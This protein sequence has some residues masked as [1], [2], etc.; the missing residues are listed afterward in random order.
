[1][2]LEELQ[3]KGK[4]TVGNLTIGGLGTYALLI[5]FAG[6]KVAQMHESQM[7][8]ASQ[9][10]VITQ[11]LTTQEQTINQLKANSDLNL[12]LQERMERLE[13]QVMHKSKN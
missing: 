10:A 9:I 5:F 6:E 12:K 3:E 7:Q 13:E 8:T 1:M 4:Q 2:T 11:T